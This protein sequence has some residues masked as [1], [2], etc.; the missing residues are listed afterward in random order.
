[1]R[2][3]GT[4]GDQAKSSASA[5][6]VPAKALRPSNSGAKKATDPLWEQIREQLSEEQMPLVM[7]LL[8]KQREFQQNTS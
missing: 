7:P 6:V 5:T 8:Q 2:S 4:G 1:M 3:P